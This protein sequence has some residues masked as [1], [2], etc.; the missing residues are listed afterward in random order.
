MEKREP[1]LVRSGLSRH[2]TRDGIT[3]ELCIYR[4]ET[5]PT[6]SLEVVNSA[7]TSIVWDDSFSTGEAANAEFLRTIAEEGMVAFL[8]SAKVIPFRR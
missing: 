3:V 5:E 1:N 6:W 8:D 4:L 7:G 2:L